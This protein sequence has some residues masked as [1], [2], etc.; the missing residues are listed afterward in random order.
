VTSQ[1]IVPPRPVKMPVP[2][3]SSENF[4]YGFDGRPCANSDQS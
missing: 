4:V 1:P 3:R 2:L